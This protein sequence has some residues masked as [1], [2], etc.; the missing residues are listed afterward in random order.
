MNETEREREGLRSLHPVLERV[1]PRIEGHGYSNK[2]EFCIFRLRRRDPRPSLSPSFAYT[3]RTA[4]NLT[5]ATGENPETPLCPVPEGPGAAYSPSLKEIKGY[6]GVGQRGWLYIPPLLWRSRGE[7]NFVLWG[8]VRWNGVKCGKWYRLMR[9]IN[10]SFL[11]L[12]SFLFFGT[13][14][15]FLFPRTVFERMKLGLD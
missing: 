15:G 8:F 6:R 2:G 1:G 11:F 12:F 10:D 14:N 3:S 4:N 5:H 7:K 13:G 9:I